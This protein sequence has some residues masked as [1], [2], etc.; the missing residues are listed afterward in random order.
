MKGSTLWTAVACIILL[1]TVSSTS[2]AQNID[3][4]EYWLE[5]GM[6]VLLVERHETPTIMGMIF[7]RVGSA[8]EI[9]GITGISHLFEHMMFK[10]TETLGTK[11]IHRDL[12]II[13]QLDSLKGAMGE[14]E[15]IMRDRLRRGEIED[16]LSPG[17]KTERYSEL[18]AEFDKLILQQRELIFK[19]PLN[20]LYTKHGGF[21]LNAFTSEDM[22][23]YFVRV[24]KN[25]IELYMWLE[26]DRFMN[27]VFREFYTERDVVREERRM[28][29]ESTPT[30]LIEEEFQA[31]FWKSSSYRWSVLGW[32]S[33]LENITREKANAYYDTYYA[34]NNL[35]MI[36]VGDFKTK[37][38]IKLV[39]KY[40][41]R[42]PRGKV[43][44]PDVVTLEEKQYAEKKMTAEAETNA[45]AEIM[46]H[47]VAF[48][49]PDS[50]ALDVVAALMSDKTG[51]LYKKLVDELD[52]AIGTA[53]RGGMFSGDGLKVGASQDIRRY[54]GAFLVTAEG[55]TGVKPE[56]LEAAIYEVINDLRTNP[57][58]D[59]ELQKVKNNLRV[60]QIRF[61]DIM[62]GIGM[63]FYLGP[64]A[65]MGDWT[66][67]NNHLDKVDQVTAD[68]VK[69]VAI[70]YFES[71]Q[72]NILLINAK[73]SGG[74]E[75]KKEDGQFAR[76]VQ[77]IKGSEDAAKLEQMVGMLSMQLDKIEDPVEK[78]QMEQLLGIARE[79]IAELKTGE[80]K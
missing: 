29:L 42:I 49:H 16:L 60:D 32:P 26:S 78:E 50:Y 67:A 44:P 36:L 19:E 3:A 30:G 4:K 21:L 17:S 48:K 54:A 47:T 53:R 62:S 24:P 72:R 63:L 71:S 14:E 64:N 55:K 70:E 11:D 6:Q 56:Q 73:A 7:A 43:D 38:M 79:R 20:E 68:D 46:Y 65:A 5:N 33:D 1:G 12:E 58:P 51:R 2:L 75:E 25:K 74:E 9:T 28:S 40:F 45:R 35:G 22:T 8:N 39:S 41:E 18:D 52:I 13:A 37:D 10:G 66:E 76:F 57:V 27:P 80:D 31:M 15:R 34:P 59:Q 77:M 61:M 23:G 69:R